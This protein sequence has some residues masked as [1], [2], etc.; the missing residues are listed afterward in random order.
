MND[1][2]FEDRNEEGDSGEEDKRNQ[3]FWK[4]GEQAHGTKRKR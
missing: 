3:R 1:L 2:I 4:V